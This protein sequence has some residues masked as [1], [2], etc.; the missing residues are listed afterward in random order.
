MPTYEYACRACD[1]VIEVVQSM[2]DA[3]LVLCPKCGESG[4]KRLIGR[5]AG[6][7]FKGTGFYETDYKRAPAPKEGGE[8]KPA[9]AEPAAAPSSPSP[10]PAAPA[11][12][13]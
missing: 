3:P 1:E 11:R 13:G 2:R 12:T 10:A 7:I 6:I 5:G 9:K 4:L 8:T